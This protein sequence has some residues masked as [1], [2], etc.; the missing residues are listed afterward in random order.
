LSYS[1][2]NGEAD[3]QPW[4]GLQGLSGALSM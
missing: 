3:Y 1:I 4:A 2:L